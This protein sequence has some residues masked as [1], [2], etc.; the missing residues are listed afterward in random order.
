MWQYRTTPVA[1][2]ASFDEQCRALAQQQ[3]APRASE[4]ALNRMTAEIR[5]LNESQLPRYVRV[6]K[7]TTLKLPKDETYVVPADAFLFEIAE[8]SLGSAR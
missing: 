4:K 2:A 1:A 6:T 5:E 8:E 3:L 7:G